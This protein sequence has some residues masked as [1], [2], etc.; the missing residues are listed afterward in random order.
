M[1][2]YLKKVLNEKLKTEKSITASNAN[3][4]KLLKDKYNEMISGYKKEIEKLKLQNKHNTQTIFEKRAKQS[5]NFLQ[6]TLGILIDMIEIFVST[7]SG[8]QRDSVLKTISNHDISSSSIERFEIYD[9]YNVDDDKRFSVI[10]Q[11]TSILI[12]KL[13]YLQVVLNIDIEKEIAR[14]S[15]WTPNKDANISLNISNL[16]TLKKEKESYT[17][18]KIFSCS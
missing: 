17:S 18:C 11:I 5:E 12:S 4:T 9:S 6:S 14:V 10:D 15:S 13:K 2:K 16:R 8:M 1:Y 7:R 3:N